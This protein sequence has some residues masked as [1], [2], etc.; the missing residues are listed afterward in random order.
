M[1]YCRIPVAVPTG[2]VRDHVVDDVVDKGGKGIGDILTKKVGPLPVIAW[3]G[4][5]GAAGFYVYKTRKG[6]S[7]GGT[8][9]AD[10]GS[11]TVSATGSGS[12]SPVGAGSGSN[13]GSG[14]T[15]TPTRFT[16]NQAWAT[17]AISYLVGLGYE[18]TQ[19]NQ[20]VQKYLASLP[21]TSSQSGMVNL[22]I[23]KMGATPEVVAPAQDDPGPV[24]GPKTGV[25]AAVTELKANVVD[26][27]NVKLTWKPSDG[28][29]WYDVTVTNS[30]G[31]AEA[32]SYTPDYHWTHMIG[33]FDSTY[34]VVAANNA[35][36]SPVA[37]VTARTP[38]E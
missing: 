24:G 15:D 22:A 32:V 21:L 6:A 9:P 23:L 27:H 14:T 17:A 5:L 10:D 1:I 20:A 4:V 30:G 12:Y 31:S 26:S 25:P 8:V 7:S 38:D 28:A 18:G 19:V 3:V 34:Y 33:G 13:P 35:G 37:T 36:K 2:W 16:D 11:G 29:A